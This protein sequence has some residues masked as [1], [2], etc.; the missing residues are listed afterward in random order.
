MQRIRTATAVT[1]K[2]PYSA[3]GTPG[4]FTEGDAVA[5]TPATVLGQDWPN[6]IQEELVN[7]LVAAGVVPDAEDDSQLAQAIIRLI[8][9]SAYT[10]SAAS[11]TVAG[12]VTLSTLAA[13]LAGT[14]DSAA[15]TALKVAAAIVGTARAYTRQQ[16]SAPVTRTGQ[17]G[18]QA[19]DCL[20]H[21]LLSVTATGNLAWLD[22]DNAVVGYSVTLLIYSASAVTLTWSSKYLASAGVALPSG[23]TAGEWM[24]VSLYCHKAGYLLCTGWTEEA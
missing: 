23:T 22:P 15:M 16:A 21:Q 10:P 9:A 12:L 4:F 6:M 13:A 24:L 19:L 1:S 14:D 3:E 17:S 7:V 18:N 11:E 2:P 20:L 8:A 5:G